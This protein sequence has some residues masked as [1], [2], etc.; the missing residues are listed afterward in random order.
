MIS[1]I[2]TFPELAQ[3]LQEDQSVFL[4]DEGGQTTHVVF[5]VEQARLMFDDYL[6]REIQRGLEQ[7]AQGE[8]ESWDVSA[9]LAEAHRRHSAQMKQS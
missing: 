5:P 6:Q 9:T 7:S 2:S 4:V 3:A 1:K 8:T